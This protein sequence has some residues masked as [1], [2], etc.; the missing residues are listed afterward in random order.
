MVWEAISKTRKS[1]SS[2]I[3]TPRSRSKKTR[4]F[5]PLLEVW[6]SWWNTL[7]RVWYITSRIFLT[8]VRRLQISVNAKAGFHPFSFKLRMWTKSYTLFLVVVSV[9]WVNFKFQYAMMW[10]KTALLML[11]KDTKVYPWWHHKAKGGRYSL[12]IKSVHIEDTLVLMRGVRLQIRP[13][14]LPGWL[15]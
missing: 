14:S 5:N 8:N 4:F 6:I 1:I 7:S 3:Q 15:V 13:V 10:A 2:G 9:Y 11:K 12:K